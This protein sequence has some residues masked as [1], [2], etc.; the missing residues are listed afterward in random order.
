MIN[1]S[2]K[3]KKKKNASFMINNLF[4]KIRAA[5]EIMWENFVQPDRQQMTYS[6]CALR[7]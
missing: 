6:A 4:K 3:K 1:V 5:Y 7:A 2:D